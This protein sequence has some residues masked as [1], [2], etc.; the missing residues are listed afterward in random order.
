MTTFLTVDDLLVVTSMLGWGP[1]RDHGLLDSAAHRPASTVFGEDA[2]P[3]IHDKVAALLESLVRNHAL[4]DGNKRLGWTAT[5]IFHRLNGHLLDAPDDP[6]YDLVISVAE[7]KTEL[8]AIAS[9]LASWAW[10]VDDPP[11]S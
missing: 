4:V 2:Y 1:V 3:G 10:P 6:A 7:G 9:A 11:D 5:Y 8:A